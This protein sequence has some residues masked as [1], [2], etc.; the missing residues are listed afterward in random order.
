VAIFGHGSTGSSYALWL[1]KNPNPNEAPV[2]V[3]GSEGELIV[4]AS[5]ALEFCRLL[6]LGYDELEWDDLTA[7]PSMWKNSEGLRNWL[8]ERLKIDFPATG[9]AIARPARERHPDFSDW[10]TAWQA[11]N[12]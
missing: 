12:L 3:F 5:N 6:G 9:D 2:V 8:T 7:A 10:M 4:L 1:T 11:A